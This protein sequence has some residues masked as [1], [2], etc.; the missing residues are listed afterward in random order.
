MAS[1]DRHDDVAAVRAKL[2][3]GDYGSRTRGLGDVNER[4]GS[5]G[6][7]LEQA[8][9]DQL[10]H[11]SPVSVLE[12]G[13]GWGPALIE[14]AWRFRDEPVSFAGINLERK[15][16]VRRAADLAVVAE[17]LQLIPPDEIAAFTPPDVHFYDA[18]TLQHDDETLDFVYSAVTLRFVP[19]KMRVI[20]EVARV[21]RPGGRAILDVAERGWDYPGDRATH[22]RL[23]TERPA[24]LVLHH[25]LELVPLADYLAFAGGDRFT[26][27]VP[28]GRR[29]T[30]DVT[31]HAR[32]HLDTGLALDPE[33]TIP[34]SEFPMPPDYRRPGSG[35]MRSAYAVARDRMA[36]YAARRGASPDEAGDPRRV[37]G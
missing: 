16:P 4:L 23:L 2:A 19:D 26:I 25:E 11:R 12:I 1:A 5:S 14:L 6:I 33:R 32:G 21:L 7:T 36:G 29:C 24:Y 9:A 13:F 34:M 20:D 31:K 8:I 10:A 15:R 28:P 17:A 18:T 35:V 22:P 27:R 30:V 3:G 37:S